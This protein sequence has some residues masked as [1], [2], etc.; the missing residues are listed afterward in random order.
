MSWNAYSYISQ[1]ASELMAVEAPTRPLLVVSFL[2]YNALVIAF[3][4]GI[5]GTESRKPAMRITGALL[6]GFGLQGLVGLQFPM[7][8]RGVAGTMTTTDRLHLVF[9]SL[10]VLFILLFIGFG[11]FTH[12]KPFRVYSIVTI[13][14]LVIFGALAGLQ[15][16]RIAAQLPTPWL[17]VMERVN[18][19]ASML[20]VLVFAIVRLRSGQGQSPD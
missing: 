1:S 14:V 18:I 13:L 11:A 20:W 5:W 16:P 8:L 7:H 2:F 17:G 4:T 6:I 15:G 9:T 10:T 12:A 3:G 19:Y